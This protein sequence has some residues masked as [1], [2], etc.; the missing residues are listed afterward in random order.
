MRRWLLAIT[1]LLIPAWA[2]AATYYVAKTGND[3]SG[4]GTAG[5][6]WLTI[7]KCASVAAAGDT[8]SVGA[9]T[10]DEHVDTVNAGTSDSARITYVATGTVTMK[11]FTINDP[12]ITV[13]GFDITGATLTDLVYVTAAG[14][15]FKL[16]S[17][18]IRDGG[19]SI[20]GV[21]FD[22]YGGM[23]NCEITNNTFSNLAHINLV[24]TGSSHTVSGNTF[25]L[26]NND[27]I[28]LFA[29]NTT[30]RRNIFY[31]TADAAAGGH[32]DI[33]Q[34]WGDPAWSITD[35][36]FEEN[37]V[38]S[39]VVQIGNLTSAGAVLPTPSPQIRTCIA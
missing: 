35:N 27:F 11:G 7:G 3:T 23:T 14:D 38:E 6:P 1:L 21:L 36:V 8:C 22:V 33:I 17:N 2:S 18:T 19:T 10:Y 26:Q 25:T 31:A 15:Y 34:T 20:Y 16:V 9:G 4:N 13:Q 32:Q 28:R 30:I 24:L 39:L 5:L 37:W 29:S 12:Y